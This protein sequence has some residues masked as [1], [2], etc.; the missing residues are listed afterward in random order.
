[1]KAFIFSP[2]TSQ[3]LMAPIAAPTASAMASETGT[4]S[5]SGVKLQPQPDAARAE[6]D[7]DDHRRQ[8]RDQFHRQIHIARDDADGEADRHDADI[9]RLLDDV[10]EDADLE[11]VRDGER[12]DHQ[13]DQQQQPDK[14]VEQKFDRRPAA[15]GHHGRKLR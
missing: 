14:V 9:G 13:D 4:T 6:Q 7:A 3:P 8:R 11:I 15:A 10:G 1:M 2:T 12:E 5:H